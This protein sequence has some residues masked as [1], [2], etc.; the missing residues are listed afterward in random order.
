M[1]DIKT[2]TRDI[3]SLLL[4]PQTGTAV[5][6]QE[7]ELARFGTAVAMKMHT[8]LSPRVKE[9]K[10][11]V[12]YAS[13]FGINCRRKLWYKYNTPS[14]S[15][16]LPASVITKFIYGDILEEYVLT[17][18]KAAGHKVEYEQHAVELPVV[19]TDFVIRG[20]MDAIIDD[21][22]VDVKSVTSYGMADARSGNLGDKFGYLG[23][24]A[25]YE[26]ASPTFTD[27]KGWLVID[28]TLGHIEYHDEP[29]KVDVL[30]VA[31]NAVSAVTAPHADHLDRLNAVVDGPNVKLCKECSYC[32]F[33]TT[34]WQSVNKG[35]GL[36]TF[37]YSTGPVDFV[38]VNKEPRVPEITKAP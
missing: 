2:L 6:L 23:Q 1:P 13:E 22:V 9:R 20:R 16:P 37:K 35:K 29:R 24:L 7:A 31:R 10:E 26:Y 33:K 11:G 19:G 25:F 15:N 4:S 14:V 30:A 18:A 27:G 12:L 28:K 34:C 32:E 17:L 5:G 21:V 3:E 36:R 8:Q 38:E